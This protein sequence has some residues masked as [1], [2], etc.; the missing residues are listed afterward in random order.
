[1]T[2]RFVSAA[3][4][5]EIAT[6]TR[7]G[8]LPGGARVLDGWGQLCRQLQLTEL[9]LTAAHMARAGS[10]DWQHRD[11]FDRMLVAQSQLEAVPLL[12]D[13]ALIRGFEEVRTLWE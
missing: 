6:K 11:P 3:S 5:F 7:V 13:D 9:P 10:M 2:E 12:T 8:K 4:A 1:M